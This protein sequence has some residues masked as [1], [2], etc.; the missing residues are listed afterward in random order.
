MLLRNTSMRALVAKAIAR[1][2]AWFVDYY[3]RPPIPLSKSPHILE[4]YEALDNP[5]YDRLLFLAP[6]RHAKSTA[7]TIF[8]TVA[9][10]C[11]N[12]N[13]RVGIVSLNDNRARKFLYEIKH[14]L[15]L[16]EI[17]RDFPHMFPLEKETEH[18]IIVRRSRVVKEPTVQAV[19][20]ESSLTG[21][22]LDLL[23]FDDIFER[24]DV[25]TEASRE[26]IKDRFFREFMNT[27]EPGG[28]AI[29]VG[30]VKHYADLYAYLAKTWGGIDL[31]KQNMSA[32]M[33]QN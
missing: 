6:R 19:G 18:E 17:Q 7:I 13:I 33:Q 8:H 16:P 27:L 20:F 28:R 25:Y 9:R 5:E 2:T 15:R 31:S 30:T 11:A 32:A 10:I 1:N 4:W 12:P 22:G 23:I 26:K 21:A 29:V 14:Y 24:R 3:I